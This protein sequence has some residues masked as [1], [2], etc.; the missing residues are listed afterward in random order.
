MKTA[1]ADT[2]SAME[3]WHAESGSSLQCWHSPVCVCVYVD[4]TGWALYWLAEGGLHR[5]V[6]T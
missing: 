2:C 6:Y 3:L 4:A 5:H 1:C